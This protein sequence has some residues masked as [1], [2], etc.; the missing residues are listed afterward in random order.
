MLVTNISRVIIF[1]TMSNTIDIDKITFDSRSQTFTP[2]QRIEFATLYFHG[3]GT[4]PSDGDNS[5]N[6]K[7]NIT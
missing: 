5:D 7:S 3:S 1:G 6:T 2:H 4:C